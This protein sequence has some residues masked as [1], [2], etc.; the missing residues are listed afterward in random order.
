MQLISQLEHGFASVHMIMIYVMLLI[1]CFC[2]QIQT[3][4]VPYYDLIQ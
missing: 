2:S 4:T 3:R 1:A